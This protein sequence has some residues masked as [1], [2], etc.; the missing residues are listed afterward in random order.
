L[1]ERV[2]KYKALYEGGNTQR[3]A[4]SLFSANNCVICLVVVIWTTGEEE[5]KKKG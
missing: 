5:Q 3:K 4:F 1:I 2:E